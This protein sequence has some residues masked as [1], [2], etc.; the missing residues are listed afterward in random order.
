MGGLLGASM[1]GGGDGILG[2]G[3]GDSVRV[4][5]IRIRGAHTRGGLPSPRI[6]GGG[7]GAQKG[8]RRQRGARRE[9]RNVVGHGVNGIGECNGGG[10]CA[11]E[12]DLGGGAEISMRGRSGG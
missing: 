9:G 3:N 8:F 6:G 1:L 7:R 11:R 5:V 10:R 4:G 12:M 2:C